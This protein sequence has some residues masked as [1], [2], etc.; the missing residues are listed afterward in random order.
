MIQYD[1]L[2][3]GQ[4]LKV[5]GPDAGGR[6]QRGITVKVKALKRASVTVEDDEGKTYDFHYAHGAAQ[7]EA[8]KEAAK[9]AQ[10]PEPPKPGEPAKA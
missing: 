10:P 1:K 9:P 7:L 5:L 6:I 8:I 2:T 3:V 4:P